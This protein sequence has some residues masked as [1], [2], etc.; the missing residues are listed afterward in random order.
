MCN[1][2][3]NTIWLWCIQRNIWISATYLPGELNTVA[4]TRSRKFN[5][6]IEWMLNPQIFTKI[7]AK[8]GKPDI[9]LFASRLNHQVP[10]YVSW[11]PDPGAMAMDAFSLDWGKWFF[12]AFPPFCLISRVLRKIQL[13]AAKGI[14]I[15]PDW[16]TQS[17]Y[18]V[19]LGMISQPWVLLEGCPQLV[20]NP[21]T[22]EPHPCHSHLNLLACRI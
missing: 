7:T 4:D 18:P 9:D 5:D 22:G 21:A 10:T 11:E 1:E 17:W 2:L 13:D 12:Y 8:F 3:A 16:P 14:L 15:I 6:N 20:T 19:V